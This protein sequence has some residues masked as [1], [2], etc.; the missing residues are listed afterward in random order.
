MP[1][2][3]FTVGAQALNFAVLVW[4]MKRFLYGPILAAVD[5]RGARV[6]AEL[7]N[8]EQK[9]VEAGRERDD[10]RHKNEALDQE[11]EALIEAATQ[12]ADAE[13]VRLV[14]AARE[15]AEAEHAKLQQALRRQGE[16][17]KEALAARAQ[18]EVFSIARQVLTDLAS[19][20]LEERVGEAFV[21]R[22]SELDAA[23]REQLGGAL[24]AATEPALVRTAFDLPANQRE[25]IR[26]A[27]AETLSM[28]VALRF[29]TSPNLVCGVELTANGQKVA[30]SV[31]EYLQSLSEGV[32]E[33]LDE[34]GAAKSEA[35]PPEG[36]AVQHG[37]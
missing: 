32:D 17:L 31:A 29:E 24:R 22:V 4:L 20:S 8:A 33:L 21:L 6:A 7:A 28:D 2:D 11:R 1:I 37:A 10:Y 35:A 14:K 19:A 34:Q 18:Q 30:W 13:G 16:G 27:L 3:W 12:A 36:A 15:A 23:A 25:A 9:Q 26:K 5:A